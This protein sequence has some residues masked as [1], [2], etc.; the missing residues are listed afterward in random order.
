MLIS[1][2]PIVQ[3]LRLSSE[4]RTQTILHIRTSTQKARLTFRSHTYVEADLNLKHTSFKRCFSHYRSFGLSLRCKSRHGRESGPE[5][6]ASQGILTRIAGKA[7]EDDHSRDFGPDFGSSG[8]LDA[9]VCRICGIRSSSAQIARSSGREV[10][11]LDSRSAGA[12]PAV[13]MTRRGLQAREEAVQ[14]RAVFA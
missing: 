5:L 1:P 2:S 14:N 9:R 11:R 13:S 3:A 6:D 10:P 7:K 4:Q 12:R 8:N